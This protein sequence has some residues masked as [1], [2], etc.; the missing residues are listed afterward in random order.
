MAIQ[1]A[2]YISDVAFL[3]NIFTLIGEFIMI[4]P[5]EYQI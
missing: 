1:H 2:F 4:Q 3:D 5:L